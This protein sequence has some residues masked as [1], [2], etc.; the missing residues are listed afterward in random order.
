MD[1]RRQ[2]LR[3]FAKDGINPAHQMVILARLDEYCQYRGATKYYERDPWEYMRRKLQETEPAI[4]GLKGELYASTRDALLAELR[5]SPL[6]DE[7]YGD[8]RILFERLLG[9]GDFADL[10][11][12]LVADGTPREGKL[13]AISTV[14]DMVKP[15]NLFVE[16]RKPAGERAPSWEKLIKELAARL[17]ID[18]LGLVL[19]RK[20]RT[21]RRKAPVLR[22]LRRNVSEYC[23]VLHIPTDP[24]QTFTPFM[25]P[26]IEGLIAANLRFLNKYR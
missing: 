22:R 16:E 26:R 15:S 13:R 23:S 21:Q 3:S 4:E 6:D 7:R 12:H 1:K 17:D 8:F 11:I 9:P 24:T 10:A 18:R 25:L 5:E 2:E 14:L 20:P 19:A